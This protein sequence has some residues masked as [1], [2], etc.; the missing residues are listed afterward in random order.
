[1]NLKKDI[2]EEYIVNTYD[3]TYKK[4]IHCIDCKFYRSQY[5]DWDVCSLF[6]KAMLEEDFCSKAKEKEK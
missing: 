3:K 4:I 1:M 6:N 2:H 5:N